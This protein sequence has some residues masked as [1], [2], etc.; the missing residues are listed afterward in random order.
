MF[1]EKP[2]LHQVCLIFTHNQVFLLFHSVIIL[3]ESVTSPYMV[4]MR[5]MKMQYSEKVDVL[6]P[7]DNRPS[8]Y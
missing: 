3:Y 1:V 2:Q 7:V 8:A 5:L 6:G 4:D